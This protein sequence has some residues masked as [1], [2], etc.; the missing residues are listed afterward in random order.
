M[1]LRSVLALV[2]LAVA[3]ADGVL[4]AARGVPRLSHA[5]VQKRAVPLSL[6]G[7]TAEAAA[8]DAEEAKKLEALAKLGAGE[9]PLPPAAAASAAAAAAAPLLHGTAAAP[10][11]AAGSRSSQFQKPRRKRLPVSQT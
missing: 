2:V 10:P 7:G 5:I 1:L 11:P 9:I 8:E 6:R 3:T 4:P